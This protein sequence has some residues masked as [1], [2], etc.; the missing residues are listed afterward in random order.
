MKWKSTYVRDAL[1]T[2][3]VHCGDRREVHRLQ[4]ARLPQ[5][6]THLVSREVAVLHLEENRVEGKSLG[7]HEQRE[8]TLKIF[9]KTVVLM[10]ARM[11]SPTIFGKESILLDFRS[12]ASKGQIYSKS[13][14]L[15][16]D[17]ITF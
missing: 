11:K 8:H 7:E 15:T 12:V 9:V 10:F 2:H 1:R 4:S 13:W 14:T 5:Q 3:G 16:L 17:S 6:R